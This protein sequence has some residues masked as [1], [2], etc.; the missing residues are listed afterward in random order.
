VETDNEESYEYIVNEIQ[1]YILENYLP[2][3]I[4]NTNN[5]RLYDLHI[6]NN[7]DFNEKTKFIVYLEN[8]INIGLHK[9]VNGIYTDATITEIT[10]IV[11]IKNKFCN[12]CIKNNFE[13]PVIINNHNNRYELLLDFLRFNN[14]II[15]Y[16][17]DNIIFLDIKSNI[18]LLN[19]LMK[20]LLLT[21]NISRENILNY[22]NYGFEDNSFLFKKIIFSEYGM[23][24]IDLIMK[25]NDPIGDF[26]YD[27]NN[28]LF[29]I[30][31][32]MT[33]VDDCYNNYFMFFIFFKLNGYEYEEYYYTINKINEEYLNCKERYELL[34]SNK[35]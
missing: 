28:A 8:L 5:V 19:D 18:H 21:G 10:I 25:K 1:E 27:K 17:F 14:F 6:L 22:C 29:S 26:V 34:R 16:Y 32:E 31:D 7:F 9:I 23:E 24:I 4:S 3:I 11:N 33:I 35:N 12:E 13:I 30:V 20:F 15:S 2:I